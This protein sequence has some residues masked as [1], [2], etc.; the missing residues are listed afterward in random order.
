MR[1]IWA[2]H[3][4]RYVKL[5][6]CKV[7]D[8]HA[9]MLKLGDY[10]DKAKIAPQPASCDW[11]GPAMSVISDIEG[12]AAVGDCV[13]AEEA[14]FIGVV[15]GNA[16]SLYAYTTAQTLAAYSAITGY[17]PNNPASDQGTDPVMCLNY[18][19][20][21]AYADGSILAGYALVDNTNV[22]EVKFAINGL[23]NLKMWVGLPNAWVNPMPSRNGF[24]WDVNPANPSQGHCFG[25]PGYR[26]VQV[27]RKGVRV[28]G[29]NDAGIQVMTWGLIGTVTWAALTSG[30]FSPNGGGGLAVRVTTDWIDKKSG[31]APSGFA[32]GDIITD[33]NTMFGQAIPIPGPPRP[34]LPS[35]APVGTTV[36]VDMAKAWSEAGL[37]QGDPLMATV[38]AIAA[39]NAGLQAGWPR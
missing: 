10:L 25:S 12:N 17:D 29:A 19:T 28:V 35:P 21:N 31:L 14:H 36:T 5:G 30:L 7:P 9:P 22:E 20:R 16:N 13:L 18:F 2:D 32:Y 23:G 15:T 27:T 39:A 24:V 4:G 38:D 37:R 11:S 8:K 34:P 33:F 1:E 3:L 26:E 6:G